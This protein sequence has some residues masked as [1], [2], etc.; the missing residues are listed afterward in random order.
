MPKFSKTIPSLAAKK[1]NIIE[2]KYCSSIKRP[3]NYDYKPFIK[4][5]ENSK[6]F[7]KSKN[8]HFKFESIKVSCLDKIGKKL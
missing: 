7:C 1:A 3:L 8:K 6:T 4:E 5:I 2:I